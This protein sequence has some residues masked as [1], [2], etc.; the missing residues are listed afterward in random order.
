MKEHKVGQGPLEEDRTHCGSK[1]DVKLPPASLPVSFSFLLP[2]LA[3]DK[4]T[5]LRGLRVCANTILRS[6]VHTYIAGYLKLS[7]SW[8]DGSE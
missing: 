7:S 3:I 4:E 2:K 5:C 8:L 1:N 6:K